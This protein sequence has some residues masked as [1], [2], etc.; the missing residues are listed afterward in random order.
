MIKC[1][2]IRDISLVT[3]TVSIYR[4]DRHLKCRYEYDIDILILAIYRRY[5]RYIDPPLL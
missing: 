1:R 3:D 2:K 4:K 5:F